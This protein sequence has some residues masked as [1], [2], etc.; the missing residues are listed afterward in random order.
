M[1]V[2]K[3]VIQGYFWPETRTLK[4]QP[5]TSS[6]TMTTSAHTMDGLMKRKRRNNRWKDT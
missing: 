5:S 3:L 1:I 2:H 6:K 4:S